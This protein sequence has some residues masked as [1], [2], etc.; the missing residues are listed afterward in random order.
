M[1][2][3]T[4][5]TLK[6]PASG[7]SVF[8]DMG[9]R[10][11]ASLEVADTMMNEVHTPSESAWGMYGLGG[12]C[13]WYDDA[14]S[15]EPADTYWCIDFPLM[16]SESATVQDYLD[17]D[18]FMLTGGCSMIAVFPM[19]PEDYVA[20]PTDPEILLEILG[21]PSEVLNYSETFSPDEYCILLAYEYED[22][23]MAFEVT[24]IPELSDA[25]FVRSSFYF[26]KKGWEAYRER[27]SVALDEYTCAVVPLEF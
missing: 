16:S 18:C 25:P 22:F 5:N 11:D 12:E 20:E 21:Q 13:L 8:R 1:L 3:G 2:T 19:N 9:Y 6:L 23:T 14:E 10:L 7:W 4:G 15:G 24:R 17:E 27:R 26:S